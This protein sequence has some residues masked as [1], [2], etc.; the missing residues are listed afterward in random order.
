MMTEQELN[1][2]INSRPAKLTIT[3]IVQ[4]MMHL[5]RA[6]PRI[7]LRDDHKGD[8][9]SSGPLQKGR[10]KACPRQQ[11]AAFTTLTFMEARKVP[12]RT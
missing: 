9:T 6:R 1:N 5:S 3:S 10:E 8:L 7:S 4:E 12:R 11:A 2:L